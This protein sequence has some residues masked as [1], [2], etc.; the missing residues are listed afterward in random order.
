MAE[1]LT[2]EKLWNWPVRELLARYPD[3]IPL[4][5]GRPALTNLGS[6]SSETAIATPLLVILGACRGVLEL[7]LFARVGVEALQLSCAQWT[8]SFVSENNKRRRDN[9]NKTL[10]QFEP[11]A[12]LLGISRC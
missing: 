4:L 5:I 1:Q 2:H 3:A 6:S 8:G 10:Q 9:R 12:K 7:V 11:L